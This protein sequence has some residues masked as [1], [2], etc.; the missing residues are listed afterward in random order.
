MRSNLGVVGVFE[1]WDEVGLLAL[2]IWSE[3]RGE[4]VEGQVAVGHVVLNRRRRGGWYGNTVHE[5]I[6]KPWQFSWFNPFTTGPAAEPSEDWGSSLP[7]IPVVGGDLL[8]LARNVLAGNGPDPTGGA[9]HFHATWMTVLPAWAG[10]MRVLG[11]IGQ[12]RFYGE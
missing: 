2:L 4:P 7:A 1:T 5:V 3:A 6:L 8:L 12:H 9:T 10:S 11:E